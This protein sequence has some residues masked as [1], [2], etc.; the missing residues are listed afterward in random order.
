MYE[1]MLYKRIDLAIVQSL[2]SL[3]V[4]IDYLNTTIILKKQT[5]IVLDEVYSIEALVLSVTITLN[6][7]VPIRLFEMS[8]NE[9]K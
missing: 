3:N 5:C 1:T 4:H 6:D 9:M 8:R 2:C 7:S